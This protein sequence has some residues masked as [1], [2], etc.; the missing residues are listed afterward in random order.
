MEQLYFIVCH[1]A[2]LL[3]LL[4]AFQLFFRPNKDG[5]HML[6]S[7]M[8]VVG[9]IFVVRTTTLYFGVTPAP[10][11]SNGLLLLALFVVSTLVG[12]PMRVL[13]PYT[14]R[15]W[16]VV[17]GYAPFLTMMVLLY[18]ANSVHVKF[19]IFNPIDTLFTVEMFRFDILY[20]YIVY[21]LILVVSIVPTILCF[22]RFSSKLL[23]GYSSM[24]PLFGLVVTGMFFFSEH[25][26]VFAF[27][28]QILIILLVVGI[29]IA[30]CVYKVDTHVVR[31]PTQAE[32]NAQ[33]EAL[34]L[35]A[36][37]EAE[38]ELR[39]KPSEILW[40]KVLTHMEKNEA[41]R[42]PT[43]RLESLARQLN[44][45][46]T[47]LALLIHNKSKASFSDFIANYRIEAFC[48]YVQKHRVP[49]I[50][51]L[52]FDVGFQSTSSAFKHFRRIHSMTPNQYI[53]Q[54]VYP[55]SE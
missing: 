44:S 15:D 39:S 2:A 28:Y 4:S 25:F 19:P 20:R 3:A 55:D 7:I 40:Q 27:I 12:Y 11:S 52:F 50:S 35:Q 16:H 37:L 42:D 32:V 53:N 51:D 48:Q 14:L 36:E 6:A 31:K 9:F 17:L 46:R 22:R 43:I 21:L 24:L 10:G 38:R 34:R 47:T 41:W 30:I 13:Y 1:I 54:V 23:L 8:T 26:F 5:I 18:V 33:Q 29:M 49:N 45:N